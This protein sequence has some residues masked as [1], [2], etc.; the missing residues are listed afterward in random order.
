MSEKTA[1]LPAATINQIDISIIETYLFYGVIIT[2]F[3]VIF[4]R[5]QHYLKSALV[6]VLCISILMIFE[7]FVQAKQQQLVIYN[8]KRESAFDII[9]GKNHL[10]KAC[11]SLLHDEDKL[12][13]HIQ[14]HWCHK[15]LNPAHY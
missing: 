5:N 9:E 1:N 7:H 10:F 8:I 12:Q 6:F 13:F 11:S 4:N 2:L 14:H 3:L 15:N